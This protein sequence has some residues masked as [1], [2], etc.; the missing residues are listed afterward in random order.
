MVDIALGLV[1]RG[2]GLRRSEAA[3]LIWSDT[4]RWDD[5]SGR[6]LIE[7]STADQTGVGEVAVI[8]RRVMTALDELR[9]LRGDA[10]PSVSG[11]T[12]KTINYGIKCQCCC[13]PAIRSG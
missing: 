2:C 12:A 11:M 6:L 5:G 13:C 7:G 3:V 8:T 9:Q 4:E 1:P 10:S